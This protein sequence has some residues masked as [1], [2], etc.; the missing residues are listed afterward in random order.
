MA[1][2][3]SLSSLILTMAPA[4]G[5]N[6]GLNIS[7]RGPGQTLRLQ[8][9]TALA[10]V[11][12]YNA[13][14]ANTGTTTTSVAKPA[15]GSN[16]SS[17]A[18]IGKWLKITSGG[19]ASTDGSL[20]L[21]PILSN[22]TTTLAVNA[23]S[24]MDNTSVFQIVDLNSQIDY[25]S[26]G[27][28]TAIRVASCLGKVEIEGI[29]FSSAHAL[30]GLL[31][32]LDCTDVTVRGCKFAFNTVNAAVWFRRIVKLNFSHCRLTASSDIVVSNCQYVTSVGCVNSAGGV[33]DI[34]DAFSADVTLLTA[35]SSP[36]TVLSMTRVHVATAEAACSSGGATPIYLESCNS[37]RAVGGL[38]TGTG[39]TGYGISIN[40]SGTYTIT[41]ST[42]T[43]ATNDVLFWG[44]KALAYSNHLGA[45]YGAVAAP[46]MALIAQVAVTKTI[47]YGNILF[48][49]SGD[50]SSRELYYGIINPAQAGSLTAAGTVVGDAYTMAAGQFYR[51]DTVAAGT[52]AKFHASSALPGV[53]LMVHN[54]GANA[55]LLYPN[56]SGTIDG[57]ASYSLAAGAVKQFVVTDASFKVWKSL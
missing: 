52:G 55:L 53:T 1:W 9:T 49:G 26:S 44:S 46:G 12:G 22:T 50:H 45:A 51:F 56:S 33:I 37:F 43:G 40:V 57:G 30:D 28:K 21:R 23:I 14:T 35:A 31:D 8:G 27:D 25:I 7:G 4:T 29:D 3:N 36:S 47:M 41:G 32:I 19:G 5:E 42:V 24:G 2:T 13:G 18:L 11:T 17:N 6:A 54:N 48:D 39:N 15:G 16:W 10:S 38:L 34:S 20:V